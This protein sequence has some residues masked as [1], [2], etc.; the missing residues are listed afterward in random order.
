MRR[1]AAASGLKRRVTPIGLDTAPQPPFCLPVASAV[2]ETER[3]T[4]KKSRPHQ[5]FLKILLSA[6]V[7]VGAL[8]SM[9]S[10]LMSCAPRERAQASRPLNQAEVQRLAGMRQQNFADGH[11]GLRGTVGAPGKQTQVNGW[12]DWRRSVVYV[13]VIGPAAGSSALIQAT[14]TLLAFRPGAVP[15]ASPSASTAPA[16]A[17]APGRPP[18]NA[19]T[20]GWRVRPV[21]L[22]GKEE[23]ETPL[24][25]LVSFLF[26]VARQQ[27]DRADLLSP[28]KN[29]WVRRD[30]VEGTQVDVLLGPA[31]MPEATPAPASNAPTGTASA[32]SPGGPAASS[33]APSDTAKRTPAS[34]APK[35]APKS[36]PSPE[37]VKAQESAMAPGSRIKASAPPKA[38]A[39]KTA[40]ARPAAAKSASARP[41]PSAGRAVSA[42][43]KKTSLTPSISPAPRDPNA[44]DSHGGAVGYWLDDAGRLRRLETLLAAGLPT[45]IDLLRDDHQEFAPIDALG[46]Q[47]ITPRE[48]TAPEAELVSRMRQK[49]LTAGGGRLAL[50][51]PL[52]PTGLRS[53]KGWLDWKNRIAYLSVRD[54]DDKKYDVLLHAGPTA[55]SI[56][57]TGK[58]VPQWPPLTA[59]KGKWESVSWAS[60]NGSPNATDLDFLLYEALSLAAN[61][62]DDPTHI[63][64]NARWL[65]ADT[66]G[67][68]PV[69]VFELPTVYEKNV[70]PGLS[71]MRYWIDDS[72]VLRRL[73]I[74]TATGA[75]AQLDLDP[76]TRPPKLPASVR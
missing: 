49:N 48:L 10:G 1:P 50:T 59:P 65:R 67:G 60:L 17:G 71:R 12:I 26:L 29:E 53:A 51:L 19:P 55:V 33:P 52:A 70:P 40:S 69:G 28:L 54:G 2:G 45:T 62:V 25:S 42:S 72:S 6:G 58:R 15:A 3:P 47:A 74:R 63:R 34:R 23:T 66:L 13:S 22:T 8:Y 44:L 4:V 21:L 31:V 30:K 5:R 9:N 18:A 39:P 7:A 16:A 68:V 61:Q 37:S 57:A 41:S 14:P 20:D 35:S 56:R 75:M 36:S 32:G 76:G 24:D 43:P 73:E 27:P 38:T 64:G 11:V 46:G